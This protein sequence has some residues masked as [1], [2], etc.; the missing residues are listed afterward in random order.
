MSGVEQRDGAT[1]V[2]GVR[3]A[4]HEWAGGD[5]RPPVLLIHGLGSSRHIWDLV[6]PIIGGDRRV[7]AVDQRG[8]GESDSPDADYD[9]ERIV[10]DNRELAEAL[11]LR[12]PVIVGHGWGAEV[13]LAY[14]GLYPY[15]VSAVVLVNGGVMAQPDDSDTTEEPGELTRS[16][17]LSRMRAHLDVPWRAE[18]D[19]IMLSTVRVHD[20]ESVSPRLSPENR[21]R[22]VQ[23]FRAYQLANYFEAIVAPVALVLA[24]RS[25]DDERVRADLT[26]L[27]HSADAALMGLRRSPDRRLVWLS[28]TSPAIPLHRPTELAA[29]IAATI[30][31]LDD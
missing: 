9:I 15:G 17:F 16:G 2:D 31:G 28:E 20:D 4:W 12:L 1:D 13:A 8:H 18:L 21:H 24:D 14:A 29:E 27:Q 6:G 26:R 11:N 23:A 3:L 7:I 22:I 10:R 25:S 5:A 30:A 19:D